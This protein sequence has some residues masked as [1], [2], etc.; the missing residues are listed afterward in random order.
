MSVKYGYDINNCNLAI[1][2]AKTKKDGVYTFRG[3]LYRVLK[4]RITHIASKGKILERY[5]N[6][7]V[8]VGSYTFMQEAIKILKSIKP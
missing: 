3:F 5:G 6:F 4:C 7:D 2:K 8:E 1:D